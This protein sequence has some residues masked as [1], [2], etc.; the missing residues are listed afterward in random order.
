M[1]Q[2]SAY[3]FLPLPVD[4]SQQQ[5]YK[6]LQTSRFKPV[7][8]GGEAQMLPLCYAAPNWKSPCLL[9]FL[10]NSFYE[11]SKNSDLGVL[12]VMIWSIVVQASSEQHNFYRRRLQIWAFPA[13]LPS[14]LHID[15]WIPILLLKF[16]LTNF[17]ILSVPD[18]SFRDCSIKSSYLENA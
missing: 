17:S 3:Y 2:N 9:A 14:F 10:T 7:A 8:A 11:F 4:K 5:C 15:H 1:L 18:N 12:N 16:R 13:L 6:F